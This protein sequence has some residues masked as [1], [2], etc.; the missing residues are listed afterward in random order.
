MTSP[1]D[2]LSCSP[3]GAPPKKW[4]ACP[5]SAL[6]LRVSELSN[7]QAHI[8]V[9]A[10]SVRELELLAD[11]LRFFLGPNSGR[12]CILPGWECLPYD[13]YSP[14]PEITSQRIRTLGQLC[15][16]D[17]F[18]LLV[19]AEQILFRLPKREFISG[20]SFNISVGDV[21]NPL[22]LRDQL[23][24]AGYLGVSQVQAEG[25]YAVRGGII[26]VFP[27][28][29]AAPFRLDLFGDEIEQ[30]R[31]FDPE[32]QKSTGETGA[33]DILPAREF[34]T[35][36]AAIEQFRKSFRQ[37]MP[38]D[39]QSSIIYREVSEGRFP[40]GI[41]FY[42]PLFFDS[43][44]T[45]FDYL[46]A[47]L[48]W[49]APKEWFSQIQT[50]IANVQDR[51]ASARLDS[52]RQPLSP[53][54]LCL[55]GE[56]AAQQISR[57]GVIEV[58]HSEVTESNPGI[59]DSPS[60][61][62][63][64]HK[65]NS[66]FS[67]L[68]ERLFKDSKPRV[69]LSAETP[70]RVQSLVELLAGHDLYPTPVESWVDF[71]NSPPDTPAI[72]TSVLD[73]GLVA[74]QPFVEIIVESQLYGERVHRRKRG[75]SQDPEAIIRSIAELH[76]GDPVVHLEHGIGRFG[77]LQWLEVNNQKNEFLVIHYAEEGKL[78]IP[79]VNI[80]VL[81]RY[82]GGD[83]EHAPLHRL[84]SD[85][86]KKAQARAKKRAHDA[87]A[88]LLKTQALRTLRSGRCYSVPHT[89]YAAFRSGFPYDETPDQEHAIEE[90][91]ADLKASTPMDR[92]VC[93]DVGFGKTEVALRAAFV[94]AQ[95]GYQVAVLTPTTLLA[96]QH[97]NTFAERFADYP[98]RIEELSRFKSPTASA[99]LVQDIG[100]GSVDIVIGTHRLLQQDI[101]FHQLGLV[102]IDEE[103]RFGVRQKERLKQLR[104]EVDVLTLTATPIPRTL[105][106]AL[107][108]LRSISL[109]GSPP[110]G[111]VSIKT[112]VQRY[113]THLIR[114]ACL[115][116]M[117]RGGQV[118]FLHN[119]VRTIDRVAADLRDLI[120]EASIE[121]AHGQMPKSDLESVMRDFYHQRFDVLVCSTIIE[122]GIDIP[123][124]NTMIMNR[125][126]RFG[127]AQLHQLRGRVGRSRHQAYA[128]LLVPDPEFISETAK[129][130]LAALEALTELGAGFALANHDLEIRG[131]GELLGEGQS[132]V[133][134]EIGFSMYTDYL[135]RAIRDLSGEPTE[136]SLKLDSVCEIDLD[137]SAFIPDD[138]IPDVH[139]RLVLYQR[140]ADCE[141]SAAL[142]DLKLE[143][144]DRFGLLPVETKMLF[145][146]TG[147]RIK[148]EAAGIKKLRYSARGGR[149]GF[150]PD[151]TVSAPRFASLLAEHSDL[152]SMNGPLELALPAGLED[153]EL[154]AILTD[155]LLD[156]LDES[157]EIKPL[158]SEI[159]DNL[160]N[161]F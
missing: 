48:Q 37:Q 145:Q 69:L 51:F 19:C 160:A 101:N 38:G 140:I 74:A 77:G 149:V 57:S 94:V 55:T 128:F 14:H 53:D 10:S 109:I 25:E 70:G 7:S 156:T 16:S 85:Q 121:V 141:D 161:D 92:L 47:D 23:S 22:H 43:A 46:P 34:P 56:A 60:G 30:I 31:F 139:T 9:L 66:P 89:E 154:R 40:A 99:Q 75:R 113:S 98:I 45:I 67:G 82:I 88:E 20:A 158:P 146:I 18:I 84:G 108:G 76:T 105:N 135:N 72:V 64:D 120:P 26:D 111:R 132:G 138:Y 11:E 2:V 33:L 8:A 71:L 21:I 90:V 5:G 81:S 148:G 133:I 153:P 125:A 102:I 49:L 130:R 15:Q 42:L 137:A 24:D 126:D 54:V 27:M 136:S 100:G 78:Y 65:S 112:T 41:E 93:G 147:V 96:H 50:E 104:E 117:H 86:W 6:A 157:N 131:A 151:A 63:V 1:S 97:H 35:D 144:V 73:R 124:A 83:P 155:W 3:A 58:G 122:S 52:E 159:K 118:Y 127:L 17:P 44:S 36:K 87:A 95:N 13:R 107:S 123:T 80:N 116:E 134:E 68:I 28:G 115:R 61:Y 12:V 62:P 4:P 114:E 143:L 29:A 150:H 39:P 142:Y 106:I 103:H 91:V 32:S 110:P 129:K 79:A 152:F 59:C 119:E